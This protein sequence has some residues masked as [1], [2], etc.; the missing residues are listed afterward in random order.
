[1][2]RT[3]GLWISIIAIGVLMAVSI[4][5]FA[6]NRLRPLLGLDLQGGVSVIL[7]APEGTDADTMNT[8]LD[9]IRNRV[10]AFGVG[11][12]DITLSGNTIEIQIPGL[13]DSTIQQR[14]ADLFCIADAKGA[15]YGCADTQGPPTT[16]LTGFTTFSH[17]RSPMEVVGAAFGARS[18]VLGA[19]S[20]SAA[21]VIYDPSS[22]EPRDP[23]SVAPGD[24]IS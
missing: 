3:R 12:P 20:Q 4:S 19:A 1:M 11:E 15:T 16:A 7:S 22:V 24:R 9:N 23:G 5:A 18:V 8:A 6:A 2:K 21:H 14:P 17:D 10:D 13:S